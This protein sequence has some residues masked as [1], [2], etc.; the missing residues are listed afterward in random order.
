MSR[1]FTGTSLRVFSW[2]FL[3]VFIFKYFFSCWQ[4]FKYIL[5]IM[6]LQ[7][8]QF[9]TFIPPPRCS[10]KPSSTP[11]L[12]SCP[13]VVHISSLSSLFP[14][15]FLTSPHLFC[16]YQL[17]CFFPVPFPLYS[18][19]PPPHWKHT[20]WSP[21]LWFCSCCSSWLSFCFRWFSFSYFF[22]FICW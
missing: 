6:L 9:S 1:Q 8:S 19:F 21:F 10:P 20:M 4:I 2:I 11:S 3:E 12:S 16:A 13:R 14:I 5:L 18:S 15:P 22:R 7:F 17:C